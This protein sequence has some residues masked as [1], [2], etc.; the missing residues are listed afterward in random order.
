MEH[1]NPTDCQ[2]YVFGSEAEARNWE[3]HWVNQPGNHGGP[4]GAG[5]R[6]GYW[7]TITPFTRQ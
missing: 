7:Y 6:Y 5:W 2:Q 3:A 4:G 1:G